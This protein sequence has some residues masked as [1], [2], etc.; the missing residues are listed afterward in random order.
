[1]RMIVWKNDEDEDDNANDNDNDDDNFNNDNNDNDTILGQG[2]RTMRD[3]NDG[4][5]VC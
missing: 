1:M 2:I 4:A 3:N 5:E